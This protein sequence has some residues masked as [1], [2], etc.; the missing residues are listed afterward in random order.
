MDSWQLFY[1]RGKIAI[2]FMTPLIDIHVFTAVKRGK[3]HRVKADQLHT[4]SLVFVHLTAFLPLQ[5]ALM[6][7]MLFVYNVG[8]SRNTN[9]PSAEG[10]SRSGNYTCNVRHLFHG[11]DTY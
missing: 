4:L 6:P 2:Q 8:E 1:D 10:S 7:A 11:E 5:I 9:P 3:L